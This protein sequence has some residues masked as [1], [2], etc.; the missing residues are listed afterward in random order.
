[1][2]HK[3]MG[4]QSSGSCQGAGNIPDG[5]P[6][7]SHE[8]TISFCKGKTEVQ[9]GKGLCP[10]HTEF[11]EQVGRATLEFPRPAFRSP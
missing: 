1:M 5:K 3:E 8:L 2:R 11:Q 6:P 7:V 9:A 4:G 10:E